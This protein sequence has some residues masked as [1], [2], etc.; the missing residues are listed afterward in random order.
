MILDKFEFLSLE[1]LEKYNFLFAGRTGLI[2]LA[3]NNNIIKVNKDA[4]KS[5]GA[6]VQKSLKQRATI[7]QTLSTFGCI[8][9]VLYP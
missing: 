8:Q 5:S 6:K 3:D 1:T 7:S 9:S 2:C 4:W